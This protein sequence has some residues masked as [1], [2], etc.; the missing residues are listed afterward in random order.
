[1][2][3]KILEISPKRLDSLVS[4]L[5]IVKKE[6]ENFEMSHF[7]NLLEKYHSFIGDYKLNFKENGDKIRLKKI[8]RKVIIPNYSGQIAFP[9]NLED[10]EKLVENNKAIIEFDKLGNKIISREKN[11][12]FIE[13]MF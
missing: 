2:S 9:K 7:G 8:N 6:N 5:E 1:M 4:F 3:K 11:K 10:F 13:S 12:Y